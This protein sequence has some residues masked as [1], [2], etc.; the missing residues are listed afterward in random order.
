MS[1]TDEQLKEAFNL[2]DADGSGVID[3]DEM[4]L[5]MKGLGMETSKEE[6]EKMIKAMD[7]DGSGGVDYDEFA[8]M[9]KAKMSEKDSPE[10][11]FK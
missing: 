1:L 5:A 8:K 6:L 10:E 9:M 2:F 7:K 3:V 11:I 4:S